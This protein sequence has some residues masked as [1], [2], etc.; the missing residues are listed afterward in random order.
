[1]SLNEYV[2][3][4]TTLLAVVTTVGAVVRDRRRPALDQA[5]AA[6]TLI[7]SDAVKNEITRT[8]NALN[9]NRDLRVLDLEV[10]AD[11][12]RPWTYAV[13]EKYEIMYEMVRETRWA[14]SKTMPDDMHL[15][16]PPPFPPPRNV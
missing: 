14:E 8:S 15:P 1:M 6:S 5:Q 2:L 7:N 16:E 12:M 13:R 9:A 11:K 3:I 10:W 4:G